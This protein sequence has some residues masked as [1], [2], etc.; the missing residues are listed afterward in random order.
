M[1]E[2]PESFLRFLGEV[3][4]SSGERIIPQFSSSDIVAIEDECQSLY[5]QI[6]EMWRDEGRRSKK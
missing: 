5:S 3:R 1:K 6:A 2:S 4:A